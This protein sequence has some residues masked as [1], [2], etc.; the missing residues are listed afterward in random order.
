MGVVAE[1]FTKLLWEKYLTVSNFNS[2]VQILKS[3]N[4]NLKFFL[5]KVFHN[6]APKIA[7]K[8]MIDT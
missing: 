4:K 8:I 3:T 1:T 5:T 6:E 7:L 2:R